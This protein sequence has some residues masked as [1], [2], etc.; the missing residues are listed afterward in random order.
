MR[1]STKN[2]KKLCQSKVLFAFSLL[3]FLQT[4]QASVLQPE[5]LYFQY[6]A[7][8][9]AEDGSGEMPGVPDLMEN[10]SW[11]KQSEVELFK[12]MVKGFQSSGSVMAMPPRGGATDLSDK[13]LLE[14][15]KFLQQMVVNNK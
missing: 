10:K 7:A 8:C 9:H 12:K 13:E 15:I 3:V 5:N 1:Q 4:S 14:V 2:E 11:L 6:C